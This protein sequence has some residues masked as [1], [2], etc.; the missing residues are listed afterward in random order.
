M[1]KVIVF[2]ATGG[3][4]R[5]VIQQ[6]LDKGYQVTAVVRN[7]EQLSLRHPDL[8]LVKGDVLLP[9]TFQREIARHDAVISCLGIA[10]IQKTT[11][12]SV[13]IQN[14]I[15]AM[16]DSRIKRLVCISSGAISI[17]VN[18]SW[19]MTFL[20]KNVLQRLYRPI[21]SD[22]LLMENAVADS[23]LDWTILRAPKLTNGER[24]NNYRVITG[25][26][27]RNIPKIARADLADYIIGHLQEEKTYQSRVEI[28]Y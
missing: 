12:Y 28:A 9:D 1:K 4:G 17:P 27:L 23:D 25:Q 11:L 20:I 10:K 15:K 16:R 24:S 3:T 6:A 22:M 26:P 7:P 5:H 19:I 2:G 8:K 21:Y 14:I 18:S 13:G